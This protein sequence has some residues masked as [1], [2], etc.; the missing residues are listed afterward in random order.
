V[1]NIIKWIIP[2]VHF[3][4]FHF[5]KKGKVGWAATRPGGRVAH[6]AARS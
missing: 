2:I 3:V 4:D 1:I 6:Q 5:I